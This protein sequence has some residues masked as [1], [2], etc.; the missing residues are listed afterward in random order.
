[1]SPTCAQA[2]RNPM[3]QFAIFSRRFNRREFVR[4]IASENR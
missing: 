4:H 2:G 1:M 3:S